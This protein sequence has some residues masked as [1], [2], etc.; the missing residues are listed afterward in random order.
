[1]SMAGEIIHDWIMERGIIMRIINTLAAAATPMRLLVAAVLCGIVRYGSLIQNVALHSM[2]P[3]LARLLGTAIEALIGN[4]NDGDAATPAPAERRTK[5]GPPS[6]LEQQ[7]D[8]IARLP[9]AK[10]KFVS[11]MLDTVLAGQAG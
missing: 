2:L 5:R 3:K 8:A 10:Q 1:L 11:S 7:L 6:R 4:S 9:R